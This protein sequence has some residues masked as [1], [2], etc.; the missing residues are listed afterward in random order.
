MH[1][2]ATYNK[3]LSKIIIYK[4]RILDKFSKMPPVVTQ[5]L[6]LE[7]TLEENPQ[8]N[9]AKCVQSDCLIYFHILKDQGDA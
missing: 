4:S 8:V 9:N 3:H 1:L 6:H 2:N 5:S 7:D